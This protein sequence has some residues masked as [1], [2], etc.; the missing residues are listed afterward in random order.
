VTTAAWRTI[1][2][3]QACD[4]IRRRAAL[5]LLVGMPM[6]WYAAE[7]ATG[8][9]YAVGT[10]VL[11]LAWSA[12]AAPLF[13]FVGA[14]Q[15]DQRLI[16]SGYRPRDI[17]AGRVLALLA[18]SG[19]LA[20][21]V[22]VVMALGSRPE[23]TGDVFVALGLTTLVST[24]VGWLTAAVVPRD[25]EG[26]LLLI[27]IVGLQSSIPVSGAADSLLPY[28]GPLRLTDNDLGPIAPAG[29][30]LHSLAWSLLLALVAFGLWRRRVRIRDTP[31]PGQ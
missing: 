4:L 23:R 15:V 22:G 29:V 3:M 31:T 17:V 12:A 13:A 21:A 10:G 14:R 2:Q 11:A 28:Y 25:L 8:V 26:T 5:L 9:D 20:L 19:T 6:S 24:S 16:Q 1:A 18:L 7:A 27:G 30:A